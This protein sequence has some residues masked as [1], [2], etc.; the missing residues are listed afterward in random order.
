MWS[1]PSSPGFP[2]VE[3]FSWR[4][5]RGNK[6]FI[7]VELCLFSEVMVAQG[8]VMT[9]LRCLYLEMIRATD[10]DE[11]WAPEASHSHG[12]GQEVKKDKS[13]SM[14]DFRPVTCCW[15]NHVSCRMEHVPITQ[16]QCQG[17]ILQTSLS[18]F[19]L[20]FPWCYSA[21]PTVTRTRQQDGSR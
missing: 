16:T 14:T 9:S 17:L 18:V 2:G 13:K 12:K 11:V 21:R 19:L 8:H 10:V 6:K 15:C 5:L 20:Y 4:K 3:V 1:H 7:S